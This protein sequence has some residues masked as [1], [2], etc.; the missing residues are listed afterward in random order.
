MFWK[1]ETYKEAKAFI[2]AHVKA[3]FVTYEELNELA[4]EQYGLNELLSKRE[5][6]ALEHYLYQSYLHH[7]DEQEDWGATPYDALETVFAELR[8]KHQLFANVNYGVSQKDAARLIDRQVIKDEYDG[9]VFFHKQDT[10]FLGKEE[11][12]Y[13]SYGSFTPG[14]THR[15]A[16]EQIKELLEEYGYTVEWN[17]KLGTRIKLLIPGWKKKL[18]V[19]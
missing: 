10:Y 14:I 11:A 7:L 15:Q 5:E 12:V 2:D 1:S 9:Y 18:P 8:T 19:E 16:G 3:G 17:G 13:L 4:F 6:R